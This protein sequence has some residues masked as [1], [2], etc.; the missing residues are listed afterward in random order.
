MKVQLVADVHGAYDEL[1]ERL[2]PGLPLLVLGDNLNLVDFRTFQGLVTEVLGQEDFQRILSALSGG[3]KSA[4]VALA[5]E[6]FFE[7]PENVAKARMLVRR[8]YLL[9]K[10]V[11][12]A[13]AIV[14][15][16]NVDYPDILAEVMGE[17]YCDVEERMIAGVKFGFI[18]GT[19][20]YKPSIGLPGE[21][22]EEEYAE[23]LSKLGPVDVLCSHMPPDVEELCFDTVV[24]RSWGGSAA[25]KEYIEKYSPD[26][27][28]FGHIHNPGQAEARLNGT[29]MRNVGGFRYHRKVHIVEL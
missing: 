6:K 5:R 15:Y 1:K 21:M 18:S 14:M 28:F 20:P 2:D 7:D 22:S 13:D 17:R 8:E 23:R 24:K 9:M 25:L 26:I 27:H 19:P 3:D 11:L 29:L 10:E 4:A 12:P 16:G